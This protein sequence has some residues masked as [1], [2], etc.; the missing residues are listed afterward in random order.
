MQLSSNVKDFGSYFTTCDTGVLN[1]Y[2]FF[3]FTVN[4]P[5]K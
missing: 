1:F 3:S 2:I 5:Y 4:G